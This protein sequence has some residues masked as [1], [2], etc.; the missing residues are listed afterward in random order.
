M[1][2]ISGDYL[3]FFYNEWSN[4][5]PDNTNIENCGSLNSDGKLSDT[6]C[7]DSLPFVCQ[8]RITPYRKAHNII[9]KCIDDSGINLFITHIA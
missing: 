4:G 9:R 6:S 3:Q 2:Y 5:Q 1:N 7:T 8:T